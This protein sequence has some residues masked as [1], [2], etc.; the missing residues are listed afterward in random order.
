MGFLSFKNK[1][2]GFEFFKVKCLISEV[3]S[4]NREHERV[5]EASEKRQNKK[6]TDFFILIKLCYKLHADN[7]IYVISE[8]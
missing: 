1:I 4:F 7:I 6:Y 8:I 5:C 2:T 3:S